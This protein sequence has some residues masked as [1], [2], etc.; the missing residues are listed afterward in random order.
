MC[1]LSGQEDPIIFARVK[2][3]NFRKILE[4][5]SIMDFLYARLQTYVMA[6][7]VWHPSEFVRAITPDPLGR[8]EQYFTG[9]LPW[10]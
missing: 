4:F 2:P 5:D 1:I 10:T 3:L 6:L 9:L 7:S 8:F